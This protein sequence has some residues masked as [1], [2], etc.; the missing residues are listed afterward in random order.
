MK[1]LLP[2][3]PES[4]RLLRVAI[5]G[6]PNVGKST[7]INELMRWKVCSVSKK[8][9]TTRHNAKAVFIDG[10][11][12][13]VFLDTP[14]IVD[15]KHSRKHHLGATMVVDPEHALLNADAIGVMVDASDHWR[16]QRIEENLLRLLRFNENKQ[17][18]LIV[19]KVDL[20]RSKRQLLECIHSLTEGVVGGVPTRRQKP[21]NPKINADDLFS[22]T[23]AKLRGRE[24]EDEAQGSSQESSTEPH[25]G[26]PN[27]SEVFMISALN[28]DGVDD[29]RSYLLQAA[30]PSEWMYP[31]ELVTDQNPHEIATMIVREKILNYLAKEVPYN[32]DISVT[33]WDVDS[34]GVLHAVITIQ[35]HQDRYIKYAIGDKGKTIQKIAAESRQDLASIFHC[36]VSLKLVVNRL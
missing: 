4:P 18:F 24:I 1:S 26:W 27:F 14:G 3:Q 28:N 34:S 35:G 5:V 13:I 2:V 19:N 23:E 9:H 10:D 30:R 32:L 8:V 11:T 31:K 6:E 25:N 12:Q 21:R 17:S 15:L 16:R 36:D 33:M 29:L 7:L 20:L 22:K